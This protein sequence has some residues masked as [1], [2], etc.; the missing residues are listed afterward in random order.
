MDDA[1]LTSPTPSSI[2]P[3]SPP[4]DC[5]TCH[6]LDLTTGLPARQLAVSLTLLRPLGPSSP[7]LALTDNDGRISN[8]QAPEGPSLKE[9]FDN[10]AGHPDGRM[11][12]ALK[13]QTG[14]YY[15]EGNTFFPEVEVRFFIEPKVEHY[16]VPLLLGPWSYTTYRGS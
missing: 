4:K 3:T 8:W 13:F 10:L 5:I 11:V 1:G 14:E 15:G 12:W 16:H 6:V 2:L 7:F 9:I